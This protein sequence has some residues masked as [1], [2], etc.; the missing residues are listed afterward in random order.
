MDQL[1]E[2]MAPEDTAA[3]YSHFCPQNIP[4]IKIRRIF[5]CVC[6][7]NK[8]L[9]WW[10]TSLWSVLKLMVSAK[11][12]LWRKCCA[13]KMK[14]YCKEKSPCLVFSDDDFIQTTESL[15]YS[16]EATCPQTYLA[17][18]VRVVFD[19]KKNQPNKIHQVKWI[20]PNLVSS[21]CLRNYLHTR[22]WNI[23]QLQLGNTTE[24]S[25]QINA[26]AKWFPPRHK[27]SFHI[28]YFKA[29]SC[30]TKVFQKANLGYTFLGGSE[31]QQ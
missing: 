24:H 21:S 23:C 27:C 22:T 6:P 30:S 1:P 13:R 29:F 2:P 10:T 16:M 26:W 15:W 18:V 9:T 14:I 19:K 31:K 5:I 17:E 7:Y 3:P 20:I 12:D 4:Q 25:S 28:H 11:T 8:G